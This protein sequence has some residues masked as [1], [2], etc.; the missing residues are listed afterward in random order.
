MK[1]ALSLIL[2]ISLVISCFVVSASASSADDVM[3]LDL[4]KQFTDWTLYL[5]S[6]SS[7]NTSPKAVSKTSKTYTFWTPCPVPGVD[8]GTLHF[9]CRN[10]D[11]GAAEKPTKVQVNYEACTYDSSESS[12]SSFVYK[13]PDSS[14]TD[15]F[16]ISITFASSANRSI[17]V[18]S[19]DLI[20]GSLYP[21]SGS[22]TAG[23]LSG[24]FGSS[25]TIPSNSSSGYYIVYAQFKPISD[26][27][28][29]CLYAYLR[30]EKADSVPVFEAVQG[31]VYQNG[32]LIPSEYGFYSDGYNSAVVYV[33][34]NQSDLVSDGQIT[35]KWHLDPQSTVSSL[36]VS[37]SAF[38]GVYYSGK[39][40]ST[41]LM[42]IW[43]TV[44]TSFDNLKGWLSSGF[45]SVVDAIKSNVNPP[46]DSS[47]AGELTNGSNQVENFE[48]GHQSDINSGF[49]GVS[50]SVSGL[51]AFTAAL[52][53]V[54]NFLS[55]SF[56]KLGDFQVVYTLPLLIAF[57]FFVCSRAPGASRA[58]ARNKDSKPVSPKSRGG[59]S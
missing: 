22:V 31:Q 57:I 25:I 8:S 14:S 36:I 11:T 55:L 43:E 35:V 30:P 56:G 49:A 44:K 3:R 54:G 53:F 42:R 45:A 18:L 46:S 59:S 40:F 58:M 16:N 52:A 1:R 38:S 19:C 37:G 47:S 32:T 7:Y 21:L 6:G 50:T 27:S 26:V 9:T 15:G 39:S 33:W 2:C 34:I 48:S 4:C 28:R 51:G 20:V 17:V 10:L 24:K 41:W 13:V 5:D 23:T 12:G 29:Y